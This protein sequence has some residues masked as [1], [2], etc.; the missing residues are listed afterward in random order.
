MRD[1]LRLIL[2]DLMEPEECILGR[3]LTLQ[4]I[5]KDLLLGKLRFPFLQ[6]LVHALIATLPLL[7]QSP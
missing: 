2:F 7:H 3:E 1:L 4:R 5:E 6:T